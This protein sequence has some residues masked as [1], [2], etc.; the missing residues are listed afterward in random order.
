MK[1]IEEEGEWNY[2]YAT[3]GLVPILTQPQ[4]IHLMAP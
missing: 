3:R 2:F 1:M 4:S